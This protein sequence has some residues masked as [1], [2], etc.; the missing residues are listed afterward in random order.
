MVVELWGDFFNFGPTNLF[1]L[2]DKLTNQVGG[3]VHVDTRRIGVLQ[4][5]QW[6]FLS[7]CL[8]PWGCWHCK[9]LKNMTPT[10]FLH[11]AD[12]MELVAVLDGDFSKGLQINFKLNT[13]VVD[14]TFLFSP[15]N[16]ILQLPSE[17]FQFSRV[18]CIRLDTEVA[19]LKSDK[20]QIV[21]FISA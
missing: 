4:K 3:G 8:V 5:N 12:C 15:G 1:Y 16:R 21:F 13:W 11:L 19:K 9:Q 17:S 18:R 7:E 6:V 20:W 2:V 14:L 10:Y